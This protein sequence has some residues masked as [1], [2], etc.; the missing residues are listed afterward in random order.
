M[1]ERSVGAR[2]RRRFSGPRLAV[3]ELKAPRMFNTKPATKRSLSITAISSDA[4]TIEGL[5]HYLR[6][7]VAFRAAFA[8]EE[9]SEETL[10]SDCVVLYP[11]GIPA[12]SAQRLA[13]R[14]ISSP[15]VSLVIIVTG[16]SATE[17]QVLVGSRSSI[18]RLIFLPLTIW[19]WTIFAAIESTLPSLH[20]SASRFC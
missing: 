3:P 8:P 16:L 15:T 1:P 18:N 4:A 7:R 6:R 12:R 20:R 2:F 13:R 9:P 19:P 10:R 11:D 5:G 17:C 14:L